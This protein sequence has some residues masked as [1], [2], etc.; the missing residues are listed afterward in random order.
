MSEPLEGLDSFDVHLDKNDSGFYPGF[1]HLFVSLYLA[2]S[3][4][5]CSRSTCR[6]VVPFKIDSL[7]GHVPFDFLLDTSDSGFILVLF[8]RSRSPYRHVNPI[9]PSF[10]CFSFD[11]VSLNFFSFPATHWR[12]EADGEGN[13]GGY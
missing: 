13:R 8:L 11:I 3:D 7:E 10:R 2:F 5:L 1:Q 9:M 4:V 6:H 12:A